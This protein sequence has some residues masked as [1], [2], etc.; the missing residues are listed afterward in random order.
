MN[1][2]FNFDYTFYRDTPFSASIVSREDPIPWKKLLLQDQ[3]AYF[4]IM[5]LEEAM[6][7]K[8]LVCIIA[9]ITAFLAACADDADEPYLQFSGGGFIF[10]YRLATA[11][12]GFFVRVIKELPEGS[13]LEASFENPAGGPPVIVTEKSVPSSKGYTFRT[14]PLSGIIANRP[15]RVILRLLSAE[16]GVELAHFERT[17]ESDLDQKVL[18]KTPPTVGP[19]YHQPPKKDEN[20]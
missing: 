15:Y 16:K 10:N 20:P 12:Y 19:G 9:I 5:A 7:G 11:D 14:P 13:V 2:I 17:Y 6:V 3:N 8:R 18:P 4:L 1:N